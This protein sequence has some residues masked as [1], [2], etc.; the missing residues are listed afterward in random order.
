VTNL[1]SPRRAWGPDDIGDL[2]GKT[3]LITGANS[4][5]GFE[6]A[7]ELAA[8]GAHVVLA[9]RNLDNAQRAAERIHGLA[10]NSSVETLSLDLAK[11]ASVRS[12]ARDFAGAHA[13]LDLLVNNAGVMATPLKVTDDGFELQIATNFLGHFA[14]TGLLLGH[15]LTTPSSRVVTVSSKAHL[16]GRIDFNDIAGTANY[17]RAIAY[18]RSKLAG[19]LFTYELDRRLKEIQSSSIA[20][21]VHPGWAKSSLAVSGPTMDR[22]GPVRRLGE[23]AGRHFGQASAAGALPTLYACSSRDV[24]GGEFYG[25]RGL[26]GLV[27]PPVNVNSSRQSHRVDYAKKLWSA[28]EE[29][30]GVSYAFVPPR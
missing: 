9:C 25:P 24:Q 2:T 6:A 12:A 11:L 17:N 30:T 28:S 14:L 29:L 4:G 19:L 3:A 27:G 7:L 23:I 13:R 20:V 10:D 8:H 5:I 15:L 16:I 26:G 18:G 21:A 22:S 1:G